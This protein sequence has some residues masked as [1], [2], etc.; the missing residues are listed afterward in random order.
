M[1]DTT[2]EWVF[3]LFLPK[4]IYY[5]MYYYYA[6]QFSF[7]FSVQEKSDT[8][9]PVSFSLSLSRISDTSTPHAFFTQ[10]LGCQICLFVLLLLLLARPQNKNPIFSSSKIINSSFTFPLGFCLLFGSAWTA[11]KNGDDD[12]PNLHCY[13][14]GVWLSGLSWCTCNYKGVCDCA[15]YFT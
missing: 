10:V 12:N 2:E 9:H 14:S 13:G 3:L 5:F 7:F 15:I 11:P 6:S 8:P 4:T 1:V